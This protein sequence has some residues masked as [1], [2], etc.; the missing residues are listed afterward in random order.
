[1]SE[2]Q[3]QTTTRDIRTAL[4]SDT[5]ELT[6]RLMDW[7]RLHR[8][9]SQVPQRTPLFLTIAGVLFGVASSA[10]LSLIPLYQSAESVDAWV[11]PTFWIVTV[12]STV[13]GLVCYRFAKARESDVAVACTEIQRDMQDIHETF[14]PN[15]QLHETKKS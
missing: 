12:A 15:E 4:P 8:K 9:L 7:K 14:F 3:F 13:V 6:I 2:G 10:L 1:M 11:R 5:T